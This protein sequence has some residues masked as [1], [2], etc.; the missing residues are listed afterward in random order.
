MLPR[1][2][3]LLLGTFKP[4]RVKVG[5]VATYVYRDCDVVITAWTDVNSVAAMPG[6]RTTRR[7]RIADRS[8]ARSRNPARNP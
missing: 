2:R 4:P 6:P 7:K 5:D 1:D 8:Y 3:F